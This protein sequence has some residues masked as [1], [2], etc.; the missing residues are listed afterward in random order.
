MASE[1]TREAY[2]KK[3]E[4]WALKKQGLSYAQIAKRL[5]IS[6]GEVLARLYGWGNPAPGR[7]ATA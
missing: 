4:A 1:W 7:G 2:E 6:P 3:R 5:D